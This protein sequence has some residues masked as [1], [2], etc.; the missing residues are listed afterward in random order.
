MG[1]LWLDSS[2]R[3]LDFRS[4]HSKVGSHLAG[5]EWVCARLLLAVLGRTEVDAFSQFVVCDG[6]TFLL[7][8]PLF[9]CSSPLPFSSLP[10]LHY[11]L[12]PYP[13]PLLSPIPLPFTVSHTFLPIF[14]LRQEP[15]MPQ[16]FEKTAKHFIFERTQP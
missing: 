12:L 8:P 15:S 1:Y 14:P 9:I 6:R 5:S 16:P 13:T 4:L 10:S 7:L 3:C 2:E 11:L